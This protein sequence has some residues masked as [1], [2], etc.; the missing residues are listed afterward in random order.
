[1]AAYTITT[2]T[3]TREPAVSRG[4]AWVI[5]A[6]TFGL[7]LSDYMS[8]QVLNAVFPLLKAEWALS[9][10]QLAS[11][12]SIVAL[13]VGT[14]T[15][16]LS[17]IADRWGRVNSITLMALLWSVAT[18]G[19]A[20]A[21]NYEQMFIA[22]FCIGVGEAAYGSVG[23]AVILAAFP[24]RMRSSLTASFMAGGPVGSV[25]GMA[26]GGA[27]AKQLGWRPAFAAMAGF[28]L[29]LVVLYMFIVREKKLRPLAQAQGSEHQ[30]EMPSRLGVKAT[31]MALV[32]SRSVLAAYFGSG[33]QL[34]IFG[35]ILAWLPSYFN[36]FYHFD[37]Q[38][39]GVTAAGLLL[40]L[41]VG[42]SV[43]GV[44]TDRLCRN[45]PERKWTMAIIY[46][47]LSA[48]FLFAAFQQPVGSQQMLL[49]AAGLFTVAS[50]TG[51]V[52]AM[53]ANLT[54]PSIHATAFATMTL[55]NNLVGFAPGAFVTGILSDRI[56][57]L[58]VAL[59]YVPLISIAAVF[60]F[61]YG[62]RHYTSDLQRMQAMQK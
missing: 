26:L 10:T 9:D 35:A 46:S 28:G 48:M 5:F 49:M 27:I 45:H 19:C 20:L 40:V 41:S 24:A 43:C 51:P 16:P 8:R 55:V 62:K 60:V 3:E 52:G 22:R 38:K 54:H 53:V 32:S 33:L 57:S 25:L 12:N 31:F 42:M 4:Y 15:F 13:L 29:V 23:L 18:A 7:L 21:A 58:Q 56:G 2:E 14:L 39:A 36:R 1:M 17:L 11:L 6:L 37:A 30:S 47:A 34:F 61:A 59:S 50:V 44:I